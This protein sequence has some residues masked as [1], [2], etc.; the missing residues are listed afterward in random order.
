MAPKYQDEAMSRALLLA[1]PATAQTQPLAA[2]GLGSLSAAK[3][4][5]A[6]PESALRA[7]HASVRTVART[8]GAGAELVNRAVLAP[9][10]C[11][12][13]PL[14][15]LVPGNGAASK[16]QVRFG[17]AP[18]ACS[19]LK[20]HRHHASR[21]ETQHRRVQAGLRSGSAR[22]SMRRPAPM[23]ASMSASAG[24]ALSLLQQPQASSSP[25]EVPADSSDWTLN[26]GLQSSML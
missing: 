22:C 8:A 14:G 25:M 9:A 4:F 21:T 17:T 23:L 6:A 16:P 12:L 24:S 18:Q 15:A 10:M 13:A 7:A 5:W 20:A 19:L 2:V 26:M 1:L 3:H 11:I